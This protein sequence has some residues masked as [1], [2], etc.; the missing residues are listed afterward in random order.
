MIPH[1]DNRPLT[2]EEREWLERT[3]HWFVG[4]SHGSSAHALTE[5]ARLEPSRLAVLSLLER[6]DAGFASG[7]KFGRDW[8]NEVYGLIRDADEEGL[9][10]YARFLGDFLDGRE[11][12]SRRSGSV[13]L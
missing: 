4:G 9:K 2:P 5:K 11:G 7:S 12:K 6:V 1:Q 8:V 3:A 13:N 10:R